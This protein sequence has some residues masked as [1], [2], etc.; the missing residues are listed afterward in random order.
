VEKLIRVLATILLTLWGLIFLAVWSQPSPTTA[1]S[2]PAVAEP[3]PAQARRAAKALE[4]LSRIV[5]LNRRVTVQCK[6]VGLS[7]SGCENGLRN[8]ALQLLAGADIA[9]EA[10]FTKFVDDVEQ[11][12]R[13]LL[14]FVYKLETTRLP[15]EF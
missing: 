8:K 9:S 2:T 4:M 12:E 13:K 14:P 7:T 10:Q 6:R 15:G 3:D 1:A 11:Y 5:E